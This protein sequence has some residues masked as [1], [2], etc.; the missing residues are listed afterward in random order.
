[1]KPLVALLAFLSSCNALFLPATNIR[2]SWSDLYKFP[3]SCSFRKDSLR[4]AAG[5]YFS[6]TQG[7]YISRN[8]VF[9]I[10]DPEN[11]VP[12]K[13]D[14]V[15]T[16]ERRLTK[17]NGARNGNFLYYILLPNLDTLVISKGQFVDDKEN[18]KITAYGDV[19]RF[20]NLKYDR[21]EF[22][23]VYESGRLNGLC[24]F[25]NWQIQYLNG[26]KNGVAVILHSTMP[27]WLITYRNDAAVV[28]EYIDYVSVHIRGVITLKKRGRV[29]RYWNEK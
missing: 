15:L 28:G 16:V 11:L 7:R 27:R 12:L 6:Y 21:E 19:F 4:W 20:E 14:K 2:D 23:L 24:K 25:D 9:M 13:V 10:S 17:R 18:G 8:Y 26:K 5:E 29:F 3:P 1:M 22:L